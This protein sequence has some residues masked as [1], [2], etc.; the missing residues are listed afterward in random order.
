MS[1]ATPC[2]MIIQ[3]ILTYLDNMKFYKPYMLYKT[4]STCDWPQINCNRSAGHTLHYYGHDKVF[5]K[6]IV[7]LSSP[8]LWVADTYYT[9]ISFVS[10]LGTVCV[11]KESMIAFDFKPTFQG[12]W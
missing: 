8:C 10:K 4:P 5:D 9:K 6:S 2:Q 7:S 3:N 12:K 1:S 11:Y